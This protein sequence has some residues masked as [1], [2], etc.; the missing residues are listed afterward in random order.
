[1]LAGAVGTAGGVIIATT[2]PPGSGAMRRLRAGSHLAA[3]R[4]VAERALRASVSS[5]HVRLRSTRGWTRREPKLAS[6]RTV[7]T[8]RPL[9]VVAE[10]EEGSAP[11]ASVAARAVVAPGRRE[12]VE[13]GFER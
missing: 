8:A 6:Q 13:F 11:V 4:S 1:M 3:R 5:S 9:R 12:H 2:T 10:R 7:R